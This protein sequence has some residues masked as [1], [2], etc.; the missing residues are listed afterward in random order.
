[1]TRIVRL[2]AAV[3]A[4]ALTVMTPLS[5]HAVPRPRSDEWWFSAWGV[6]S[7]VWPVTRGAGVTVALL[8]SGVNAK[9]PELS[10]VV[11]KGG[12]ATG[13]KTDGRRDVDREGGGHGT[14][15][16]ALIAGQGGGTTGFTG[17]A[18]EAKIL[19]VHVDSKFGDQVGVFESFAKGIRFAVDHRAKV[20]NLSVGIDST[21]I[22]GHCDY[23]VQDAVAYAIQHDV[24]VVAAAGN[25]GD[26][27][28]APMMPA[29]CAG[30]LAVGAIDP[31][32]RPWK[33]SQRQPY[34]AVAAPGAGSGIIGSKGEYF[35]KAWGTS[36]ATALTSGAIALIRSHNPRMPARTVV[37]RL[38]ATTL[39]TGGVGRNDQTGYGPIQITSAMNPQRYPV[40]ADAP[41]PVYEA[42]EKWQATRYGAVSPPPAVKPSAAG[43]VHKG[44]GTL[45]FVVGGAA[46]VV[47]GIIIVVVLARARGKVRA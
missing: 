2:F 33:G 42:F 44:S 6:Q 18:P 8:D 17:I 7:D 14:G 22:P 31:A 23:G 1:L 21:A 11:L 24:I 43:D 28:N 36:M 3:A 38:I 20:I 12:D 4:V 35:R 10:G 37:Q 30:V 13:E 41:N 47:V 9:L 5:A 25:E 32:L 26:T 15:M 34:V 27:T 40:P 39:R 46:I 29:S 16:A 19:P 45:P